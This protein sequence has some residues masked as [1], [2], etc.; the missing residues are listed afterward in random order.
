MADLQTYVE[1]EFRNLK[2]EQRKSLAEK[3]FAPFLEFP[4]GTFVI[5]FLDAEPKPSQKFSNKVGFRV[6][7]E[8]L[9]F[10]W[11]I[12]RKNPVYSQL[13]RNLRKGIRKMLI[14]R[15]GT[16]RENTKYEVKVSE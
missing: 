8:D 3:G 16:T 14:T 5:E 11:T 12:N 15:T 1:E 6:L 9:E 7:K 4:E 2:E 10:E 13:I